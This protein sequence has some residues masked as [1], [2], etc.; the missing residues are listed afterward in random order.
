MTRLV[1][2]MKNLIP[3]LNDQ[4]FKKAVKNINPILQAYKR[5]LDD[6]RTDIAKI[7]VE[8]AVDGELKVGKRQR[9]TVLKQLEKQLIEQ[10]KKLGLIDI[11]HTTKILTDVYQESYYKTAYLIDSGMEASISFALLKPEFVK[12]AVNMPLEG[13]MFSDRIWANK[14]L[15]VNRVRKTVEQAMIQGTSID[16]LARQVK[17][18]FGS[19]A[20]ESRRL[21]VTE[22]ARC[23]SMAQSEIY[24]DCGVI[25]QVMWTSTIEENT[26]EDCQN[27]DGQ[28]FD[29]D[30]PDK[31]QIP[32]HP[33]C[34]CCW[35]GRVPGWSAKTRRE[36]STREIIDYTSYSEWEKSNNI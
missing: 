1:M 5:T 8:Y 21:V 17:Y 22:V 23:Q 14:E 16:K 3:K 36:Q 32:L 34:R 30:D 10:G 6:V 4:I 28:V 7:Y 25:E 29:I 20:Y 11:N 18:N 2:Q 19:S 12:A 35:I 13:V 24:E 27:L 31:P 15:L 26:C 33:L 9:Y